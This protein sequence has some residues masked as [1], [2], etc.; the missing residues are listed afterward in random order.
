MAT[1]SYREGKIYWD[2]KREDILI[3]SP[4]P[5]S[6]PDGAARNRL[7]DDSNT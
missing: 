6:L 3:A 7:L 1:R 4:W 5:P 2:R